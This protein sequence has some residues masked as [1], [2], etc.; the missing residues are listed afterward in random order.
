MYNFS[1][2]NKRRG[3]IMRQIWISLMITSTIVNS[4]LTILSITYNFFNYFVI[5]WCLAA[6]RRNITLGYIHSDN[7]FKILLK[8]IK[9]VVKVKVHIKKQGVWVSVIYMGI[10][11]R[12]FTF[13]N[14]WK[15]KFVIFLFC[16]QLFYKQDIKKQRAHP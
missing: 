13:K 12:P 4:L 7:I 9:I 10:W 11:T 8:E 6:C 16:L 14:S 5:Y 2:F 15:L 1:R 3:F